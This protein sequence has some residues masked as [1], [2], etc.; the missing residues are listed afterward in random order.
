MRQILVDVPRHL[1][2][3]VCA[4]SG[5]PGPMLFGRH[6]AREGALVAAL[7]ALLGRVAAPPGGPDVPADAEGAVLDLLG[8]LADERTGG[9]PVSEGRRS[10]LIVAQDYIDRHLHDPALASAQVARIMGISVRHLGRIFEPTGRSPARHGTAHHGT[11]LTG[12][13][14]QRTGPGARQTTIADV[15]HRWGFSG[16]AHF[17]RLFRSRIGLT[18]SEARA[19]AMTPTPPSRPPGTL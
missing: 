12:A 3:E 18:P 19:E 1:F 14:R 2:A 5:L 16:Q 11:A 9:R 8:R 7:G 4:G 17:A 15:A 13:H 10:Q 6:A